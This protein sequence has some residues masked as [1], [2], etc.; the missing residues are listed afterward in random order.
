MRINMKKT[1]RRRKTKQKYELFFRYNIS[2]FSA[3]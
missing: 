1:K 3:K 2:L